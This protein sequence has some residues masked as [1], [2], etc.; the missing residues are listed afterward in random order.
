M[1]L[2]EER[3]HDDASSNIDLEASD[4]A[5]LSPPGR[6][7]PLLQIRFTMEDQTGTTADVKVHHVSD[8]SRCLQRS[9]RFPACRYGKSKLSPFVA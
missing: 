1:V 3:S 8:A 2:M 6:P 5:S 4:E 7:R 9:S